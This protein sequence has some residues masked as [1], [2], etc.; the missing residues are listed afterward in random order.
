MY[1]FNLIYKITP[2]STQ[3]KDCSKWQEEESA[4]L[5]YIP[6]SL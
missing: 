2:L 1:K 4:L 6:I 5:I 3:R